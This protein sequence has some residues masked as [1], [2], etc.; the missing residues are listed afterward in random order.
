M[1]WHGRKKS[2][3]AENQR[4]RKP[5]RADEFLRAVAVGENFVQQRRALD[6]AGFKRAPFVR[7][8]DERNRVQLPRPF[9]AARIAIDV[10]G[11]ALF[12]DEPLAGVRAALQFRRAEFL[13]CAEQ[14]RV[15]RTHFAVRPPAIRQT[16]PRRAG[17][18]PANRPGR[19]RLFGGAGF[20]RR[21]LRL[22]LE[23]W[24]L[25]AVALFVVR[26]RHYANPA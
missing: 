7:R 24:R 5:A 14:F 4:R 25:V 2:G 26:V 8:D 17:N 3:C 1:P 19:R 12:V 13:Q 9:H 23:H 11:D 22:R 18:R 21:G 16:R 6:Q 10:V 20:T 15:M